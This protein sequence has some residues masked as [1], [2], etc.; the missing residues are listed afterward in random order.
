VLFNPVVGL[1]QRRVPSPEGFGSQRWLV[2]LSP[3]SFGSPWLAGYSVTC[4]LIG[5]QR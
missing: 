4:G 2:V 5:S 1:T 3:G